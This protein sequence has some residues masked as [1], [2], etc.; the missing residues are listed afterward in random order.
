MIG[1]IE[2]E[3]RLKGKMGAIRCRTETG[4][5]FKI[6]TGFSDEQR[7]WD[8]VPSVGEFIRYRCMEFTPAGIPRH[9]VFLNVIVNNFLVI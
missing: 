6:G 8:V 3:G 2:G 9:P 7:Q 1:V 5:E 4:A